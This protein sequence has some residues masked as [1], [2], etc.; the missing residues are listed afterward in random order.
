LGTAQP[1][2]VPV[3]GQEPIFLNQARARHLHKEQIAFIGVPI[4]L[5]GSP[6]GVLSVDRLFGEEVSLEEDLRLLGIVASLMGQFVLLARQGRLWEEG[7]HPGNLPLNPELSEDTR[8]FFIVA[9]EA[10][11]C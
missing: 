5:H 3:M 6:L 7:P 2:I 11:S 9:S 10:F 8:N 1:F 4:I